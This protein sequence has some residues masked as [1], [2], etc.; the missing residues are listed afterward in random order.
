MINI[1]AQEMPMAMVWQS[2]QDAVMAKDVSG[3]T[4]WFHRQVD[5]RD[6][7]RG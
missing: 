1:A 6:M 2:M 3:Y 4:Y 5:F 7:K